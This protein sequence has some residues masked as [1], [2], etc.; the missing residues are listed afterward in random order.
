[1]TGFS[2][3]LLHGGFREVAA[4]RAPPEGC[5]IVPVGSGSLPYGGL[6]KASIWPAPAFPSLAAR[7]LTTCPSAGNCI[8]PWHVTII[9]PLD[10][11]RP[12]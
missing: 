3:K 1:M 11:S 4:K 12:R 9:S 6:R 8:I 2:S 10:S 7:L 5:R